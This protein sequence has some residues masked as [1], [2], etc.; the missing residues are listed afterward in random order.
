MRKPLY[1]LVAQL[2]FLETIEPED[3]AQEERV[4]QEL[5]TTQL[6]IETKVGNLGKYIIALRAD[7]EV[8]KAEEKRLYDR[9][10]AIENR[11]EWLK[12]Y[13][14]EQMRNAMTEQV[15]TDVCTISI[16][17]YPPS[18]EVLDPELLP[19]EYQRMIIEPNKKEILDLFKRT[20]VILDGVTIVTDRES[21]QIR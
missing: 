5:A 2:Q 7:T 13:L 19:A 21:I 3:E 6:D 18:V 14:F 12:K 8:F 11:V 9:R 15:K 16:K 4:R 17:K 10:K 1:E 20:G